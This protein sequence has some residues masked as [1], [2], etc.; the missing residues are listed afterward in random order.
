EI[1][2]VDELAEFF[3]DEGSGGKN[4]NGE[5]NPA[6]KLIIRARPLSPLDRDRAWETSTAVEDDEGNAP[7][8]V[9]DGLP[10]GP[11]NDVDGEKRQK[12]IHTE[13]GDEK[14]EKTRSKKPTTLV[15]LANVRS[16]PL[17][18]NRRRIAFTPDYSGKINLSVEDS[19]AD[20]N[21]SLAIAGS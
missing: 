1:T 13:G 7:L 19:G 8:S 18:S 4:R 3:A 14:S 20:R 11:S 16:V 2:T 17:S 9:P 12:S 6:G 5:E 10:D 21:Y 15:R